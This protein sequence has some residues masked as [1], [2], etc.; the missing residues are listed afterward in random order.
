MLCKA[1]QSLF[2]RQWKRWTDSDPNQSSPQGHHLTLESFYRSVAEGCQI[3][4]VLSDIPEI[5]KGM[6]NL[7]ATHSAPVTMC[8]RELYTPSPNPNLRCF[9]LGFVA[10]REE[11]MYSKR[12][13]KGADA[14]FE[15]VPPECR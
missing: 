15:V 3:C 9:H 6:A 11:N 2:Q 13:F 7:P 1:C 4:T 8:Q 10:D 14:M 5:H 12:T